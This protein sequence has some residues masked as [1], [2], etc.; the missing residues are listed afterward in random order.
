[1][2]TKRNYRNYP[3]RA[4]PNFAAKHNLSVVG[5]YWAKDW[6]SLISATYNFASGRPYTDPNTINFLGEKTKTFNSLNMSWAYL[7]SQQKILFV[8]VSN[9]LGFDNIFNYQYANTPNINGDFARRAIRPT[10]DRFF[11]VGFFWTISDNKN[12]NQLDNL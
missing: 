8:S 10:A 1:M 7:I 6:K 11:I 3:E 4:T 5:K 12:D 9:V 2:D